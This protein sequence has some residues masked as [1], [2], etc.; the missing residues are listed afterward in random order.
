MR[1]IPHP[2]PLTLTPTLTSLNMIEIVEF[3]DDEQALT[4]IWGD[5]YDYQ[6]TTS[7][8]QLRDDEFPKLSNEPRIAVKEPRIAVK[9]P[10]KK[11]KKTKRLTKASMS[12][13]EKFQKNKGSRLYNKGR[14]TS[15]S[16]WAKI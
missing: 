8:I 12:K 2:H 7:E 3:F 14:G 5:M 4:E 10:R 13:Y 11:A 6:H 16:T 1:H 15:K 9:E